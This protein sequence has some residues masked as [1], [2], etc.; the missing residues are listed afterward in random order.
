MSSVFMSGCHFGLALSLERFFTAELLNETFFGF[1]L[2][3]ARFRRRLD[4]FS[5]RTEATQR[6][7]A[8][9]GERTADDDDE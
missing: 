2:L 9:D 8:P 3:L 5:E 1:P 7:A 4:E 6:G